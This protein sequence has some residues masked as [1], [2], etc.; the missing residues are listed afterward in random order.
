MPAPPPPPPAP[1]FNL[2]GGSADQGRGALLQSI[3]AGKSLKKTVT[4]DKSAPAISGKVHGE[5]SNVKASNIN[6]KSPV[7]N[8]NVGNSIN[9][10]NPICLGGLFSG[11]M[12]KLK[13]T[14]M[15]NNLTERDN[16][17]AQSN[18]SSYTLPSVKRGP[19]PIPP[20]AAQKPLIFSPIAQSAEPIV[21]HNI[22]TPRSSFGKPTLAPKPPSSTSLQQ[23]PSPPP[24][25]L[26]LTTG[27]S[28]SRAQSMR[29]A[30]S[31]AV[32]TPTPPSLHQPSN[33]ILRPPVV[34]PPSPPTSR[35]NGGA[36]I[37]RVAPPPPCR[38]PTMPPPPPPLPHRSSSGPAGS[39]A[40][41]SRL[42]PPVPPPP[43]PPTRGQSLLQQQQRNG[44][45]P[46][47]PAEF[48]ARFV[49]MFHS[50][51]TFPAPEPYRGVTKVYNSKTVAKQQAPAPPARSVSNVGNITHSL[52][53]RQ[54]HQHQ[55]QQ[56]LQ[57]QQ[58]QQQQQHWQQQQN[59]A[60][61]AC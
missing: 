46:L 17:N 59:A 15:R 49:D 40:S 8:S 21:N 26:N 28:V 58:Q 51:A 24:K 1:S 36:P 9:N 37:T 35:S 19:P 56:Q 47:G 32:L 5:S 30:R 10:G 34:R 42:A 31:P 7:S 33:R 41:A 60:S 16:G 20:P 44:Q 3:R 14:G 25:K 12:P 48:E 29:L 18:M 22:E 45:M 39:C 13:S 38:A 6:T 4:V 52:G 54:P 57:Q 53:A 2:G 11:G 23:K 61:S 50:I 27:N 55:H 43:T